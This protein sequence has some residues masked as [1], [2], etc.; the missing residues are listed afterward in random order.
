MSFLLT[1]DYNFSLFLR[2]SV[3]ALV[4]PQEPCYLIQELD[5]Q[6]QWATE[7]CLIQTAGMK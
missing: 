7:T 1:A 6:G 4:F 5:T 2:N 3:T